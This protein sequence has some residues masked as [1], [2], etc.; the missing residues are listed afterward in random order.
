MEAGRAA[1]WKNH[2]APLRVRCIHEFIIPISCS[3]AAAARMKWT[4]YRSDVEVASKKSTAHQLR[5]HNVPSLLLESRLLV[6]RPHLAD[7]IATR[8]SVRFDD[9]LGR[10]ARE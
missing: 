4:Q 5:R 6:T 1:L 8:P 2:S 10:D 7:Q 9:E 3:E